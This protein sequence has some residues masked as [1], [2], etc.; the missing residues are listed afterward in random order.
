MLEPAERAAGEVVPG[1][2]QAGFVGPAV[3]AQHGADRP[4]EDEADGA[5]DEADGEQRAATPLS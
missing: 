4:R 5:A 2:C 1:A 3:V